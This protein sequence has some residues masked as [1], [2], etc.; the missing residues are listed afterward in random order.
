MVFVSGERGVC[1][2]GPLGWPGPR[3]PAPAP[4]LPSRPPP[5]LPLPR[6]A[7]GFSKPGA[8]ILDSIQGHAKDGVTSLLRE[9][10]SHGPQRNKLGS[11]AAGEGRPQPAPSRRRG[12]AAPFPVK[13]A[14]PA[15][16]VPP[17]PGQDSVSRAA[18]CH[19]RWPSRR[20]SAAAPVRPHPCPPALVQRGAEG[21]SPPGPSSGQLRIPAR[22]LSFLVFI[23]TEGRGPS[24]R[25]EEGAA[26]VQPGWQGVCVGAC[27][28]SH[29]PPRSGPSQT[30]ACRGLVQASEAPTPVRD[31]IQNLF[32]TRWAGLT[33]AQRAEGQD[34][35][36]QR[37]GFGERRARTLPPSGLPLP[38]GGPEGRQ[39]C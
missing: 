35:R 34:S 32:P 12:L 20:R 31:T 4:G 1:L 2:P 26:P 22:R 27:A 11:Q 15:G 38:A 10:G 19:C 17:A 6:R 3:P 25:M 37:R 13:R 23:G 36:S 8:T 28:L 21:T 14:R 9:E 29:S 39:V 18:G 30:H 5:A 7:G 16:R 33:G 24:V